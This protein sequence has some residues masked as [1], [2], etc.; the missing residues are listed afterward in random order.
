MNLSIE[1]WE[2][3]NKK[4][5]NKHQMALITTYFYEIIASLKCNQ[6]NEDNIHRCLRC[7]ST[8]TIVDELDNHP[9][10]GC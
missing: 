10:R 3:L 2:K 7:G 8:S 5:F 6:K 4:H 1:D 9:A